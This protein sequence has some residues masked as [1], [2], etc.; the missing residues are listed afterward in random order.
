MMVAISAAL[1]RDPG[2]HG[3]MTFISWRFECDGFFAGR[4]L[5]VI[6]NWKSPARCT[7]QFGREVE[8]IRRAHF[9]GLFTVHG[10]LDRFRDE[11][12]LVGG[13]HFDD[14]FHV[15]FILRFVEACLRGQD[16]G[17]GHGRCQQ[18]RGQR[19]CRRRPRGRT[20]HRVCGDLLPPLRPILS[21]ASLE[22]R[23]RFRREHSAGDRD[24]GERHL[25]GDI[26]VGDHDLPDL[27]ASSAIEAP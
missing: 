24:L 10:N 2:G 8:H 7:R 18:D 25:V 26:S 3:A 16:R 11:Q 13:H 17:Q 22:Q 5:S 9:V 20:R 15:E 14:H 1:R 4:S 12:L 21:L 23:E 27:V 6:R 19:H